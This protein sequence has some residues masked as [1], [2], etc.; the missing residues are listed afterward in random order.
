LVRTPPH[1]T[2]VAGADL[3]A[4]AQ[5]QQLEGVIAKRATSLYFPGKRTRP[6]SPFN[7][8]VPRE[9]A[10]RAHWVQPDLVGE[11]E[12]RQ[13]TRLDNRLRHPSWR[14]LRPDRSPNDIRASFY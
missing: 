4:V 1:Y 12:H 3:L 6:T 13:W 5:E 7:E 2:D 10:R 14:G 11:I 8:A 9:Y